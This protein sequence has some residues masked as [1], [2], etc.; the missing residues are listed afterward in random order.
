MN[1]SKLYNFLCYAC[2]PILSLISYS[3][4]FAFVPIFGQVDMCSQEYMKS[5]SDGKPTIYDSK[6]S[7]ELIQACYTT[8]NIMTNPILVYG[9]LLTISYVCIRWLFGSKKEFI[10]NNPEPKWSWEN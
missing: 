4:L 8:K 2:P 3:M 1:P 9:I 10:Q 5:I 7:S 6:N